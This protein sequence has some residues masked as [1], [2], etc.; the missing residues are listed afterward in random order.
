[1]SE[2]S[3]KRKEFLKRNKIPEDG[4]IAKYCLPPEN[5]EEIF[6]KALERFVNGEEILKRREER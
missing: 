3:E 2:T 1:M 6:D 4:F 5:Q